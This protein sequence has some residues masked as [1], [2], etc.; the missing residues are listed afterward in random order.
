MS[1]LLGL[2]RSMTNLPFSICLPRL[3][4]FEFF[5]FVP[6]R[7]DYVWLSLQIW[8]FVALTCIKIENAYHNRY[9]FSTR[10]TYHV[11]HDL[12]NMKCVRFE[13]FKFVSLRLD[14]VW[15]SLQ[16]WIFVALTCIKIEN[17]YHNRYLF[18]TRT[19]YHVSHDL[20]NMKCK[21]Q[22]FIIFVK[23]KW[24]WSSFSWFL[25][26]VSSLHPMMRLSVIYTDTCKRFYY[27][28]DRN[29]RS[30]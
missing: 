25:H 30:N 26:N 4:R 22:S 17:A 8:I 12:L 13:F 27:D 3:V 6:L 10:T 1:R 21:I 9:L 7:L 14:Y 20:L 18:S 2:E 28:N 24:L 16:I 19:T 29:E 15:L 23:S 5:K 11:S